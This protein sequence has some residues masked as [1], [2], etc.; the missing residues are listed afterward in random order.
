MII[1]KGPSKNQAI[2]LHTSDWT[3][4]AEVLVR[5]NNQT[6]S[7]LVIEGRD[8]G[9]VLVLAKNKVSYETASAIMEGLFA[10]MGFGIKDNKV[11]PLRLI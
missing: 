10:T 6:Q 11:M 7:S 3:S 8:N 1:P 9:K 4:I 5:Y 2:D